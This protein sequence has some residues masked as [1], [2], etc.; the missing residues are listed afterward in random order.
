MTAF[1]V[2][3][4]TITRIEEV[5]ELGFERS[6]LFPGLDPAVL[7]RHPELVRPNFYDRAS[8]RFV[9]SI[10]GWLIRLGGR[11][12]L[13]DT[14]TG[15]GKVRALPVFQRFHMLDLPFVENLARAGVAPE[16][17]DIVVNTHLHIDHVGWNTRR[18]SDPSR[19]GGHRWVPAFPRARYL[20]GRAEFEHWAEGGEGRRLFPLNTDVILDSVDPVVEAGQVDLV[21]DG[22][23]IAPGLTLYLAPGHTAT[24]MILKYASPEG[25]FVCAADVL[26]QPVQIY[27]PDVNSCFCEDPEAARATRRALLA[28][29]AETGALLLPMHFGPPHAG[30]VRR[31]GAGYRFEPAI[32]IDGPVPEIPVFTNAVRSAA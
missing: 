10:Q 6:F 7:D 31:E 26:H 4:A 18:V 2:G 15:N 5:L 21:E 8:G 16:D 9:S 22:H 32:P 23:A 17:V 19:P 25:A 11:T 29:C 24:Q 30:Y 20:I 12:I 3:A 1:R 14:C 27:D 28:E 13:V